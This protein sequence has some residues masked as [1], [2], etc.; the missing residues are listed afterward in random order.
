VLFAKYIQNDKVKEQELGVA[1]STHE[2]KEEC[3]Q[4][5]GGKPEKKGQLERPRCRWENNVIMDL[6][7]IRWVGMGW[8]H[9]AQDKDHRM[10]LVN[11][12]LNLRVA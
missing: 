4:D 1:C 9:L 6:G 8:I 11:T 3:I 12:I 2:G 5:F 10:V 7:E